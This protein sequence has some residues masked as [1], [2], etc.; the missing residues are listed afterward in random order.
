M[1]DWYKEM[2]SYAHNDKHSFRGINGDINGGGHF[3]NATAKKCMSIFD[4]LVSGY[5]LLCPVDIF[6]D[7]TEENVIYRWRNNKHNFI[8]THDSEQLATY[9]RDDNY[10]KEALRWIP[11]HM[12]E[13]PPGYSILITHPHHGQDLPFYTLPGIIDSDRMLAA[14]AL[15]FDLKKGYKGIIKKG[16]PIAQVMPFKRED[17]DH[18]VFDYQP[19]RFLKEAN[20]LNSAFSNI[21]KDNYWERKSFK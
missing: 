17:W 2:Y 10:V 19:K 4:T 11:S 14:G 6:F 5:Y 1:P 21:Y 3:Q 16:T 20:M 8:M 13:T 9:P 15:P 7:S 18:Q 12:I